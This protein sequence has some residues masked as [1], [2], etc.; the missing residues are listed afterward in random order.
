MR[1]HCYKSQ[2]Q[3]GNICVRFVRYFNYIIARTFINILTYFL[4]VLIEVKVANI[5]SNNSEA[6]DQ[7]SNSN[8]FD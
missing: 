8:A 1:E 4:V 6:F 7:K 3:S 2:L 5:E